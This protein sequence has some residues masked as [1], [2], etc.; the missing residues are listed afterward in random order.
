MTCIHFVQFFHFIR[1]H[2]FP[3]THS[4]FRKH[5]ST[6]TA[7]LTIDGELLLNKLQFWITGFV[8]KWFQKYFFG[9]YQFVNLDDVFSEKLITSYGVPQG[10]VYG[11]LTVFISPISKMFSIN[12]CRSKSMQ[13]KTVQKTSVEWWNLE[14]CIDKGTHLKLM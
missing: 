10:S 9:R 13:Y 8:V 2:S 7:Q 1:N 11:P 12:I 5:L 6:T 14:R 3:A 4:A